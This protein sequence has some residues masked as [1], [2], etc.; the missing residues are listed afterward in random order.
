MYITTSTPNPLPLQVPTQKSE[1][2]N[3]MK[4]TQSIRLPSPLSVPARAP[5][6]K[7]AQCRGEWYAS[8]WHAARDTEKRSMSNVTRQTSYVTS[9]T[10]HV[11]RHA[12]HVTRHASHVTRHTS[13]VTRHTSHVTRHTSHVTRHT[14]QVLD[15]WKADRAWWRFSRPL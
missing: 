10:S 5:I 13:H 9:H 1:G 3:H 8:M 7:V 14:S 15:M 2:C 4:C 11:T 6:A 12:S